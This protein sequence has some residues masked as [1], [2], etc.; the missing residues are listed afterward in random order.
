[1][2]LPRALLL[3]LVAVSC[4]GEPASPSPEGAPLPPGA[5][6]PPPRERSW[7]HGLLDEALRSN[8]PEAF[9]GA[10]QRL[11]AA[12]AEQPDDASLRL[13]R[14]EL[15]T[16]AAMVGDQD[17]PEAEARAQAL[18]AYRE[19]LRLQ[20]HSAEALR[21]MAWMLLE[22]GAPAEAAQHYRALVEL[23]PEDSEVLFGLARCHYEQG[24]HEL[25]RERFA[26][27]VSLCRARG[28]QEG[29]VRAQEFL[30]RCYLEL[31]QLELAEKLLEE[32]AR[33]LDAV[34]EH[35]DSY[36]GC[37]YHALGELY[38]STGRLELAHR[39]YIKAAD[40]E[41]HSDE[42]QL[43]AALA[44]L[45]SGDLE[46]AAT[47]MDR[48]AALSDSEGVLGLRDAVRLLRSQ[49]LDPGMKQQLAEE[50]A[51]DPER[52]RMRVALLTR[53]SL[54][55]FDQGEYAATG[56]FLEVAQAMVEQGADG[57]AVQ[58]A[59]IEGF[60]HLMERRY[61]EAEERFQEAAAQRAEDPVVQL[62]MAHLE[63]IEHRH[64]HAEERFAAVA[65]QVREGFEGSAE[66]YGWF[67]FEMLQLGLG[68]VHIRLARH[69][70]AVADFDAI[71]AH[72]PDE[73]LAL[74]GKAS[75]L[76]SLDRLD[77]AEAA[78]DR[79]LREHP[80]HRYALAELG[81]ILY[82]RGDDVRAEELLKR[83]MAQEPERYSCP[84]EGLGLLYLRQGRIELA[85]EHLE[86]AVDI[87]PEADFH[88]YNALARIYMED[89]RLEEARA[90]LNKSMENYPL[91]DEAHLLLA[92]LERRVEEP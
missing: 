48:A 5:E 50:L 17:S 90:L 71:L 25:A 13:V 31:G 41:R 81:F 67:G 87:N 61:P 39:N 14:A 1:M 46:Q 85:K 11:D 57:S 89:G 55:S 83:A 80:D 2:V 53:A 72:Q 38:A 27:L 23:H 54:L 30:G 59:V 9:R 63:I 68:W 70:A 7:A 65:S 66:P 10:L 84:H 36:R 92:E 49:G 47:Y 58:L 75:A 60:L 64:E 18:A 26:E 40:V 62:G 8:Q 29:L 34:L 56:R 78:L 24:D 16:G 52:G 37:P 35:G 44:A 15:L 74:V 4:G 77:E 82:N 79:V 43:R 45:A 76:L 32:S 69:E 88:K 86:K 6:G 51:Q 12:I 19:T 20:P 91:D 22:T 3:A 73:P 21:G 33:G 42:A 28:D